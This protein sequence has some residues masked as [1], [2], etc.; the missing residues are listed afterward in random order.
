M[1]YAQNA[2]LQK[3]NELATNFATK[4]LTKSVANRICDKFSDGKNSVATR[5]SQ[6]F[7][8]ENFN[9][10]RKIAMERNSSQISHE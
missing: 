2:T 5:S 4:N 3:N 10:R 7:A 8:T 1:N 9:V 6:N